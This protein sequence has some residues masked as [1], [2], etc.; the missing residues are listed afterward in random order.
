M[1]QKYSMSHGI[2]KL[3]IY[4]TSW[5][6][7]NVVDWSD[8]HSLLHKRDNWLNQPYG[9]ILKSLV[10]KVFIF[11]L[12]FFWSLKIIKFQIF[13]NCMYAITLFIKKEI[14]KG[15]INSNF[16]KF[17]KAFVILQCIHVPCDCNRSWISQSPF[18]AYKAM[19]T[20]SF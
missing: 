14:W 3:L 18:H 13:H 20:L 11:F 2:G 10:V 8:F 19:A 5:F 7:C 9:V 17:C 16:V 15:F 1:H 6:V 12:L 4:V